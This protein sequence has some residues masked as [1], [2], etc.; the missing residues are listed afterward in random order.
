MCACLQGYEGDAFTRCT[1]IAISKDTKLYISLSEHECA[2]LYLAV[3]DIRYIVKL[4]LVLF[5]S[6]MCILVLKILSS[7]YCKNFNR[8]CFGIGLLISLCNMYLKELK[9]TTIFRS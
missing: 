8:V 5:V 4:L 9:S 1:F 3:F 2:D 6:S 7:M